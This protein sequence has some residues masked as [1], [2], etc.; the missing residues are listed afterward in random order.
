MTHE[1]YYRLG[2]L[3]LLFIMKTKKTAILLSARRRFAVQKIIIVKKRQHNT[4]IQHSRDGTTGA[5]E[6]CGVGERF[7]VSGMDIH[8]YEEMLSQCLKPAAGEASP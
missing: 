3:L 1:S 2:S 4:N 6:G 7:H 5:Q 8:T